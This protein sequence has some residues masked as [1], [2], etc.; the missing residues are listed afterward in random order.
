MKL[1][2]TCKK[3][4]FFLNLLK[5]KTLEEAVLEAGFETDSPM[6]KAHCLLMRD[7]I[8]SLLRILGKSN[9]VLVDGE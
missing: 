6:F 9:I 2:A 4:H 8:Q 3:G 5:G 7:D 1:K